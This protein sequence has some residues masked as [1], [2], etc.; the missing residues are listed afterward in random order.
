[1]TRPQSTLDDTTAL[2]DK[3]QHVLITT[4]EVVSFSRRTGT[5]LG[6][7][8]TESN[9]GDM[10]VRLKQDRERDIETITESNRTRTLQSLPG[11]KIEF[12]QILQDMIGDL[13]GNPQPIVVKVFG[14][15]QATI[16]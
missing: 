7:F 15:D 11:V 9:R 1:M 13:S 4:P 2:L 3:I 12:S 10:S 8:L 16:E 14:S 5:Q 6:F